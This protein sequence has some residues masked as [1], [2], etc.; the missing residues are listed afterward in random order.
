[1]NTSRTSCNT[2]FYSKNTYNNIT[3]SNSNNSEN[4]IISRYNSYHDNMENTDNVNYIENNHI[5]SNNNTTNNNVC[6]S[7][8]SSVPTNNNE[9]ET[10]I[11]ISENNHHHTITATNTSNNNNNNNN[12]KDVTLFEDLSPI[13]SRSISSKR[14]T[15]TFTNDMTSKSYQDHQSH[16]VVHLST[17]T[18]PKSIIVP[19]DNVN[20]N[21]TVP[22]NKELLPILGSTY[23]VLDHIATA[24]N[25]IKSPIISPVFNRLSNHNHIDYGNITSLGNNSTIYMF[26][27]I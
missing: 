22:L 4:S 21:G 19:L 1:M 16:Q 20:G 10:V 14:F 11:L 25:N 9:N 7:E 23:T 24:T 26:I 15:K 27:C 18:D 3:N 8:C 13:S 12:T 5:R 2:S 6:K 17:T